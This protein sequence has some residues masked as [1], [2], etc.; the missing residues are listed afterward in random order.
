MKHLPFFRICLG[1]AMLCCLSAF[2]NVQDAKT[3]A[4]L[5]SL[6]SVGCKDGLVQMAVKNVSLTKKINVLII[7]KE[8]GGG[9]TTTSTTTYSGLPP[10]YKQPVGCG[11]HSEKDS[12][13]I[14]YTIG[15]VVYP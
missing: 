10:G 3:D 5:I 4:T 14:M 7:K 15:A 6:G 12:V 9:I 2:I 8:T 13:V 11:G 1:V